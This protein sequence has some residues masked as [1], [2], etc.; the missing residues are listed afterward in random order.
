MSLYSRLK[1]TILMAVF[2]PDRLAK[3]T[4]T[5]LGLWDGLTLTFTRDLGAR[6]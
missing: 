6:R 5:A 1:S 3:L 4:L 2:E